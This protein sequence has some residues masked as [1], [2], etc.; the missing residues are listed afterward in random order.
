MKLGNEVGPK[1]PQGTLI[2]KSFQASLSEQYS[3]V[4]NW[5]A[6][7]WTRHSYSN[8]RTDL[9]LATQKLLHYSEQFHFKHATTK[10][11]VSVT[12]ANIFSL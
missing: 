7:S 5:L 6:N 8:L 3:V 10:V 11:V 9:P 2:A 4:L 12:Q 1:Y